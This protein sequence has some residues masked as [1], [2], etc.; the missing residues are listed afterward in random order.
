MT[1]I[2]DTDR[3]IELGRQVAAYY[4]PIVCAFVSGSL[5]EGI[6][7]ARSDLDVFVVTP[8]G[9]VESAVDAVPFTFGE[10]R[11]DISYAEDIR[12]DTEVWTIHSIRV[13]AKQLREVPLDDRAAMT[14]MDER[15][16]QLAHRIRIGVPTVHDEMFRSI[17]G[18]FDYARL[19]FVLC[20]RFLAD[21]L[22]DAE[23]AAGAIGAGDGGTALLTSRAALG[24]VV[25]A[26]LAA[27]GETNAKPKWRVPKLRRHGDD[28][29]LTSYLSHEAQTGI[30]DDA[31]LG[32]A[33]RRLRA[34]NQLAQRTREK[35]AAPG[36]ARLVDSG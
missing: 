34:A 22:N 13:A 26:Y 23:D 24:S 31:L 10:A 8:H 25:D 36:Y 6:G 2:R 15:R 33:K 21:Y 5:I 27:H 9:D 7:N 32:A 4:S 12:V 16:L 30:D 11:I 18:L 19:A 1:A 3:Y 20:N 14:S 35:I 17:Q 28:A 29:L